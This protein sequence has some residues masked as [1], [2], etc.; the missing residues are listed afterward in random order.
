MRPERTALD[1]S[2]VSG[3][4]ACVNRRTIMVYLTLLAILLN[5]ITLLPV[6]DSPFL[7]DDSWRESL[8]PGT[9]SLSRVSLVE[10]S[11]NTLK[12]FTKSGRWY[13][14]VLY[15]HAVFYYL[16]RYTYKLLV[17]VLIIA[18][19]AAFAYFVK[20]VTHSNSV[21][22]I[23]ILLSPLFFQFRLYHDPILS[24]YFMMQL[25]LLLIFMSLVFFVVYRR[26]NSRKFLV[27][28]VTAYTVCLLIYEAA[29]TYWIMHALVVYLCP[30]ETDTSARKIVE[31]VSPFVAVV[32]LNL[33][34]TLLVRA[35]FGCHYEGVGLNLAFGACSKTFL[36]QISA[37]LPLSYFITA[38][39]FGYWFEYCRQYFITEI[40]GICVF[41]VI[42]W[43]AAA[44]FFRR[45][46]RGF[47]NNSNSA[48]IRDTVRCMVV[49]GLGLWILPSLLVALSGKYQLELTWGLGYLPVYLSEFGA[50]ML[51]VAMVVSLYH[52]VRD[53]H[54]AARNFVVGTVA[55]IGCVVLAV[56]Y[57]FN[58]IVIQGYNSDGYYQRQLVE[59][60]LRCGLMRT[61]PN[62]SDLICGLPIR[63]WNSPA[64][65]R[66]H[67]GLTLQVVAPSG[68]PRDEELGNS[69]I[70]QAFAGYEIEGARGVYDFKGPQKDADFV[71]GYR[72]KFI[73]LGRPILVKMFEKKN[74][75]RKVFFLKY[76]AQ[77]KGL[78]YAVLAEVC[79]LKAD[80][81]A[82]LSVSS[83]RIY[84]Y[85]GVPFGYKYSKILI[86]GS[87]I[88]NSL[89]P[90]GSLQFTDSD[91]QLIGA[92]AHGR[93]YSVPQSLMRKY[94][95]PLSVIAC[96]VS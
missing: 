1:R 83:D 87:W 63:G 15:Y 65:Y 37:A 5:I 31:S 43:W 10:N 22:L 70:E 85:V 46:P 16:D 52:W 72:V 39:K 54:N 68:F 59:S 4:G 48:D 55:A 49:L 32:L 90:G 79:R 14:L 28:S 93:L 17:I 23:C 73:G 50:I 13:P 18:D 42:L 7:G 89:L 36:K 20:L 47:A 34:I 30:R 80:N 6:L 86:T 76:E 81:G 84:I 74:E 24:Y 29:Y 9:L 82:I 53:S 62:E 78:G 11:W 60:A 27:L 61:V 71:S 26:G 94:I 91:L 88:D 12:D 45:Q 40:L 57:G 25:Q 69:R 35:K 95:D 3:A 67:A 56:N 96:P 58:R 41:W 77:S 51:V 21:A 38:G 64:F 19:I 33:G 44:D 66:M 2:A 92:D 8:L 75:S